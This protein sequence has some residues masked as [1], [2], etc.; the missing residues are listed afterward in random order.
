M[1]ARPKWPEEVV[2]NG[3]GQQTK[4]GDHGAKDDDVDGQYAP[5][6]CVSR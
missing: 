5:A 4:Q 2:V 6:N 3:R 1:S